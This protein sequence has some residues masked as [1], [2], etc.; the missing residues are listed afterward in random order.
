MAFLPVLA[1]SHPI[2]H[3]SFRVPVGC[4]IWDRCIYFGS[5][6]LRTCSFDTLLGLDPSYGLYRVGIH[7]WFHVNRDI[8]EFALTGTLYV[9]VVAKSPMWYR[10]TMTTATPWEA[11]IHLP[12]LVPSPSLHPILLPLLLLPPPHSL[13]VPAAAPRPW[14]PYSPPPPA[15][16][17]V[18]SLWLAL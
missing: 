14:S 7:R 15:S 9:D 11:T 1:R 10:A 18:P 5:G 2:L 16:S 17:P 3:F 6:E 12:V 4:L 13:T 8:I